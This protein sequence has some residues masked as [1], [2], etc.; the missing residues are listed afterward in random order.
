M[1]QIYGKAA[2]A[3]TTALG[4]CAGAP[5]YAQDESDIVVT[6]RRVEERLQDVPISVAV[7]N[8]SQIDDRNVTDLAQLAT[9]TP[10]LQTQQQFGSNNSSFS[11]RGFVQDPFTAP[12]VGVYFADV[13]APRGA[14]SFQSGDGAGPGSM[15]DLQNVQ[16]LRG[17]QGTL[18]GR[19]TTGGSILLVP[20]RPTYAYEGYLEGSVGD[21]D[22]Q[23][24]QG[25]L[26][27]PLGDQARA[28]F[29]F[30]RMTREGYMRNISGIGPDDFQDTDYWA[31][32]ASFVIDIAPDL[33]NYTIVTYSQ[34]DTNGPLIVPDEC[35]PGITL[36]PL[37]NGEIAYAGRWACD[38][39]DRLNAADDFYAGESIADN[40]R[41]NL[42]QAQIINTT[43]WDISDNLTF[44][45][46]F[47]YS[48]LRNDVRGAV[49][50]NRWIIDYEPGDEGA[51]PAAQGQ[52]MIPFGSFTAP[53]LSINHAG[54][55][56]EEMR[57]QGSAFDDRLN[58]QAGIYYEMVRQVPD[59]VGTQQFAFGNCPEAGYEF[60]PNGVADIFLD[61]QGNPI[62]TN[63][64]PAYAT[65]LPIGAEL[66]S[67]P[68]AE[69]GLSSLSREVRTSAF[70]DRAVY[71]QGTYDVTDNLYVTLGLRYTED[72]S[73]GTQDAVT[74]RYV[75]G[76]VIASCTNP[77]ALAPDCSVTARQSSGATTG[78]IVVGY[79]LTDSWNTYIKYARGYRQGLA[80][81]RGFG[82]LTA[83]DQEQVDMYEIG[84]KGNW[85]GAFPGY[86]NVAAFSNELQNMQ[87]N[88]SYTSD[89]CGVQGLNPGDAGCVTDSEGVLAGGI[90][91]GG[92]AEIR[93]VELDGA[94]SLFGGFNVSLGLA[95]L[96]SD[97]VGLSPVTYLA[98]W[99]PLTSFPDVDEDL[100]F[101]PELKYSITPS[102]TLPLSDEVGEI[103][104]SAT[105]AWTSDYVGGSGFE[106]I[107][108]YGLLNVNLNWDSVMGSKV[109]L[110]LF[111]TNVLDE[112][113]NSTGSDLRDSIGF[114][115]HSRGAPAM[116][117]ARLRY[118]FG[119]DR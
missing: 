93:G 46:I 53:G 76:L 58:W 80:N 30:D 88:F 105:W 4:I 22:M 95:Y 92:E 2:L 100:S 40:P 72:E 117:G 42:V 68:M 69:T 10:S 109:D 12:S 111:G 49:F 9:Y 107:D 108:E 104:A 16:V 50:G 34:A 7:F 29:G 112:E 83:F 17:P 21:Y 11:I 60:D 8:Q 115:F 19:N 45:N 73:E 85:R 75:S 78:E 36:G 61:Q 57:L 31:G 41:N 64:D 118:T 81:P 3:A 67:L 62:F 27:V 63:G 14:T 24:L 70:D 51:F 26:N 39:V 91:A 113:Y 71:A 28:R 86:V 97:L 96:D 18:F 103:T 54:T 37:A 119:A 89:G 77:D 65:G 74:W 59:R 47:S 110:G 114:A 6:A 25:V 90:I 101:S 56:T 84:L 48:E 1:R 94:V 44:K 32:R 15:F 79:N 55:F 99:G 35:N 106:R 66:C 23:R 43:T 13:I 87:L 20:Q 116:Y 98:G 102:Y 38:Q 52:E 82:F 5:A 33:E